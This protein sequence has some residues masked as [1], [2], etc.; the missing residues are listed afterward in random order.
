MT[1]NDIPNGDWILMFKI[2]DIGF[3]LSV[4]R[5]S[6]HSFILSVLTQNNG[7]VSGLLR[8]KKYPLVG[9]FISLNWQARLQEHLGS[10]SYEDI[11]S[12]SA[13]YMDDKRRLASISTLTELLNA[14][15][16]EREN[17]SDF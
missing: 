4:R 11:K 13:F 10:I 8:G 15:L 1:R 17:V 7:K 14:L 12:L 16:P 9:S 5:Y 2:T 6:E 3:T